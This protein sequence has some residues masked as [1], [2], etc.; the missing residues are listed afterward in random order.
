MAHTFVLVHGGGHGGWCYRGVA[1]ILR[2]RGHQVYTPT[3][4]GYG[5]RIHLDTSAATMETHVADITNVLF[6]ED[7]QDVVLVGH[8]LAG[9]LIPYV[10]E[11]QPDRIRRVV[12]YAG[13]VLR[14]GQRARDWDFDANA[15]DLAQASGARA[16]GDAG[17]QLEHQLDAFL[18]DGTDAQRAWVAERLGGRMHVLMNAPGRLSEFLALG[19]PTGY[20]VTA[21]DRALPAHVC[22][23]CASHLPGCRI[24][25]VDADH[26]SM[27]T[28][29]QETA[30][31]ILAMAAD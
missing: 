26:D 10:A 18:A 30:E 1:R 14:D 16:R 27:V 2:S 6:Y 5:E 19:I 11:R 28:A 7:L 9:V 17:A 29:P 24:L 13:L 25:E 23:V 31:A 3:L 20:I 4:T 15:P 22:R 12:W 21:R 8:S